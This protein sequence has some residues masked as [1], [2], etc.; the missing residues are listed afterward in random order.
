MREKGKRGPRYQNYNALCQ[1]EQTH[2]AVSA[3][4]DLSWTYSLVLLDS[5]KRPGSLPRED[6]TNVFPGG[7]RN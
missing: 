2:G 1:A 4:A 5:L 6:F 3:G 7:G